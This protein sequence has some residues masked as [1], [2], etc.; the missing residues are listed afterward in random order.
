MSKDSRPVLWPLKEACIFRHALSEH[1]TIVPSVNGGFH[2]FG[3]YFVL[4]CFSQA[5][6]WRGRNTGVRFFQDP[7]RMLTQ[8]PL[9]T[10]QPPATYCTK[11]RRGSYSLNLLYSALSTALPFI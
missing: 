3:G 7:G 1:Q 4:H 11:D 8:V 2:H 9:V 6:K 10:L 5:L